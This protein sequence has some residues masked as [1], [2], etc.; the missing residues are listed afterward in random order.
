MAT[1]SIFRWRVAEDAGQLPF[2]IFPCLIALNVIFQE[3]GHIAPDTPGKKCTNCCQRLA[4][5]T[6]PIF[7]ED[8]FSSSGKRDE[9]LEMPVMNT[10]SRLRF[11]DNGR[12]MDWICSYRVAFYR[13]IMSWRLQRLD[14]AFRQ[15]PA[16]QRKMCQCRSVRTPSNPA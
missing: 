9:N 15:F 10:N 3:V 13:R 5:I 11:Q 1:K 14:G 8:T 4:R 2:G 6:T 7:H 16:R 12:A